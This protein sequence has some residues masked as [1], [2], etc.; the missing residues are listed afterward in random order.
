MSCVS[1][2]LYEDVTRK[3]IPWNLAFTDDD[4]IC[5]DRRIG[6]LENSQR[7]VPLFSEIPAVS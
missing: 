7:E 4:N 2:L 3:L 1:K 5:D 6:V